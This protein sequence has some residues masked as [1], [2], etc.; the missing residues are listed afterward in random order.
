MEIATIREALL[1]SAVINYGVLL[2]WF[3]W[4][5]FAHDWIYGFH[6][7]WFKI[8]VQT[9]DAM[10]YGAMGIFKIAIFVFNLVPFLA[11]L[12]VA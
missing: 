1:W 7:K 8:P 9:F 2:W 4:F 11:L 6:G 10:H 5:V 3:V 12:I